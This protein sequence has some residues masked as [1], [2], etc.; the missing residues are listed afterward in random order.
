MTEKWEAA[1]P[2]GFIIFSV[3]GHIEQ[4]NSPNGILRFSQSRLKIWQKQ[5]FQKI[6]KDY[7]NFVPKCQNFDVPGHTCVRV[8]R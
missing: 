6:A 3:S 5:T 1:G 4:L 8:L 7:E 2:D